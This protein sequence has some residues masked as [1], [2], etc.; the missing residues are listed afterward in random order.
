MGFIA[1]LIF[2]RF[3]H[4][5]EPE[6]DYNSKVEMFPKPKDSQD[7]RPYISFHFEDPMSVEQQ[8]KVIDDALQRKLISSR[9]YFLARSIKSFS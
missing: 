3:A 4:A 6:S 5:L 1:I 8:T 2:F 9:Q 7:T